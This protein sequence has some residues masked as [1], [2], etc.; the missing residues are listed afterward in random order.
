MDLKSFDSRSSLLLSPLSSPL[1]SPLLL[2][3]SDEFDDGDKDLFDS[4]DTDDGNNENGMDDG[5]FVPFFGGR[6]KDDDGYIVELLDVEAI[7]NDDDS[8]DDDEDDTKDEQ[9][10]TARITVVLEFKITRS[11][12]LRKLWRQCM[13]IFDE[14][15]IMNPFVR[16]EK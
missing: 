8:D 13:V 5:K 11:G 4:D 3:S 1:S 10:T 12:W 14:M 6:E 7:D 15:I 16:S 9:N 2:S